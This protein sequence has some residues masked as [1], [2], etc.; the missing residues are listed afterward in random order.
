M[1]FNNY[2]LCIFGLVL[3]Q[4][5]GCFQQLLPFFSPRPEHLKL[6]LLAGFSVVK[7]LIL[8]QLTWVVCPFLTPYS[9]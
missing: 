2:K 9:V 4:F 7:H 1:S 3:R 5:A 8:T 6:Y